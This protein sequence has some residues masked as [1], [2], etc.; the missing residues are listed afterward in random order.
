MFKEKQLS[1]DK[2]RGG[3]YTPEEIARF[4]CKW[5]V[6]NRNDEILEPSCGDG[7]FIDAA[8]N[9]LKQLGAKDNKISQQILGV[10]LFAKEASK[11]QRRAKNI[12]NGATGTPIKNNDFFS[13]SNKFFFRSQK[14]KLEVVRKFDAVI[15]NPPFIRYQNFPNEHR[16][17]AFA[18]MEKFGFKTNKLTN[19]WLPFLVISSYLLK[20]NGR[21]AMVIPS[22]LFQVKYAAETRLFLSNYFEKLTIVS[23][24]KLVFKNIQQEV[25][26]LLC[27]KKSANRRKGI[28]SMELESAEAL[29]NLEEKALN[30]IEIKPIDHS[31]DKWTQY[32]L[33]TDEILLLRKIKEVGKIK[34]ARDFMGVDVG[35][36]TG[37]NDF[38]LLNKEQLRQFKLEEYTQK[39]VGKSQQLTGLIFND[40]DWKRLAESDSAVAMFFPEINSSY[41]KSKNVK[42]YIEL[43][44]KYK[45][46]KG[47]KCGIRKYWYQ[48]PS[49]WVP[50]AFALRQVQSFPKLVINNTEAVSTD[51]VHRVKFM[52]SKQGPSIACAFLNSLTFALSEVTGR[53]YGGGVLTFEPSELEELLLPINNVN[54]INF[55]EIDALLRSK[56]ID[57]VL[58]ITDRIILQDG[59]GFTNEETYKLNRIWKKLRD[60]RINRK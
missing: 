14:N 50:E 17:I 27:E 19:I 36:V 45:I 16:E 11:A 25:I 37:R 34:L 55:K 5:S 24:K 28:Q 29:S 22:E 20:S 58:N 23:F 41:R 13:Y 30:R 51:T 32:Y 1:V 26:L 6:R 31:R 49:V 59:Y 33:D 38:F 2:L 46:N 4:L 47:Y 12:L 57:D 40:S 15:G 44:E 52:N 48:V 18:L 9:R 39:I 3:Y 35:V 7:S 54:R 60:R 53:S 8:I 56:R 10:E 43:G 21:L 42:R